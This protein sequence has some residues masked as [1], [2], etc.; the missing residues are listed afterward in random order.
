MCSE[1]FTWLEIFIFLVPAIESWIAL[2]TGQIAIQQIYKKYKNQ[3]H[4]P[5][6]T[7]LTSGQR[8]PPFEQLEPGGL[9]VDHLEPTKDFF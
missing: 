2:S 4:Y 6:V 1:I 8:Y 3:L 9:S 5:L 7:N